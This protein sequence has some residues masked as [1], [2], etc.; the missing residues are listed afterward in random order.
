MIALL[1]KFTGIKGKGES[2]DRI[3]GYW[4]P[5]LVS[6]IILITLPSFVDSLVVAQLGSITVYGALG[7]GSHV[8]HALNKL[9]EA[10]PV[11]ATAVIGR[12]NGAQEYEKCGED[13]GDTFWTTFF[14]GFVQF[15][16]FYFCA[17]GFYHWLGVPED[18]VV[19]GTP[20]LMLKSF[21]MWLAFITFG[22]L[23]FIRAVK[24]TR[25]PMLVC[26]VGIVTFIF[27]DY[28]LVLG[29]FY[30][31]RLGLLGSSVATVIEY[32]FMTSISLFYILTNPDY[33]KYFAKIFFSVFNVRRALNLLNLSWP[34]VID[35]TTIALSYIWL[36]KQIAHL[37]TQSIASFDV[38]KNLE[39]MAFVPVMA[40][41][42]IITFLV[43]NYLGARDYDGATAT[44]KK[45]YLFS[46]ITVL[47]SLIFLCINATY[48][49][50][51]FDPA[52]KLTT[53]AAAALTPISLLVFFDFTQVFLAGALRGAGDVKTVM[54]TR[55]I[56]CGCFF[57]PI[58]SYFN[59]LPNISNLMKFVFIYGSFYVTTGI[60]GLVYLLRINSHKWHQQKI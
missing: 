13:L 57:V 36:A 54:W 3:L 8:M 58:S 12:H 25:V 44:I 14:L 34:I 29:K 32:G 5:E 19:H 45:L 55:V 49:V 20:F 35:K 53:F 6:Q 16:F 2:F 4:F 50:S 56:V 23:S 15:T 48:C 17:A 18:M 27:F 11:A 28:G 24:N 21:G 31:P 47:I 42:T 33:K 1:K 10:I 41:A 40:S 59:S 26:L 37:G 46:C 7:M 52:N 43:S 39:R 38:I 22:L 30:L 51:F 60:I 9:G